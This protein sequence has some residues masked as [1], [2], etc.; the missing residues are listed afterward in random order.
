MTTI[1]RYDKVS[2]VTTPLDPIE[3][4]LS[5][6]SGL[7]SLGYTSD[8]LRNVHRISDTREIKNCAQLIA[9]H[10]TNSIGLIEQAYSG[11]AIISFLP[12]YYAILNLSKIYITLS[13]RRQDLERNRW[14]GATY[15]PEKSSRD[16]LTEQITLKRGGVLPLFYEVLTRST[17]GRNDIKIKLHD[18]Y[19]RMLGISH[20]YQ[21]AYGNPSSFQPIDLAVQGDLAT[22]Y[23]LEARL[24]STYHPNAGSRRHLKILTGF[25][26]KPHEQGIFISERILA[27]TTDEA[28]D[29]LLQ[30]VK[31]FLLYE[32]VTNIFG[33]IIGCRTVLSS[34]NLLFPEEVPIWMALFHLSNIV[35]YK[36]EFLYKVKD[37]QAWPMLL[38][39]RKHTV[40]RFLL[41]F[42]SFAHQT[43]FVLHGI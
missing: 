26:P 14:H 7:S 25:K 18:I 16:L 29:I 9:V 5:W 24:A 32:P 38:A 15:N 34:K 20:E 17:W 40:L 10:S 4:L 41:L 8:I 28:H 21:H 27:T 33:N 22:G 31:R 43:V 2:E 19:P 35:R 13:G 42:W 6:I 23:Y 39:L 11:P 3:D 36:P 37:T 1:L 30:N 12:L